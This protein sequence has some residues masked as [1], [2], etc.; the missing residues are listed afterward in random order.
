[1]RELTIDKTTKLQRRI[2]SNP[3]LNEFFIRLLKINQDW[4]EKRRV[5]DNHF[6]YMFHEN[7]LHNVMVIINNIK[8][9]KWYITETTNELI[10]IVW[11]ILWEM[12]S[13]INEKFTEVILDILSKTS[14]ENA[15]KYFWKCIKFNT[16]NYLQKKYNKQG[17][18]EVAAAYGRLSLKDLKA[19]MDRAFCPEGV[20]DKAYQVEICKDK[21]DKKNKTN[22]EI[23][24]VYKFYLEKEPDSG[25]TFTDADIVDKLKKENIKNKVQVFERNFKKEK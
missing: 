8:N 1:M 15:L 22:E 11:E 14:Y 12:A 17:R 25:F 9:L 2:K 23:Q 24:F 20:V 3:K 5:S 7:N 18:F 13:G 10:I 16:L 21:E 19:Q 4:W 6:I